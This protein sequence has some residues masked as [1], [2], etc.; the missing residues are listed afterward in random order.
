MKKCKAN[1]IK[2]LAA[3]RDNSLEVAKLFKESGNIELS[4]RE[5]AEANAY[6]VTIWLLSDHDNSFE[7]YGKIYFPEEFKEE[8]K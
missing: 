3:M 6:Q 5:T 8:N 7:G 4:K 1:Y 2:I